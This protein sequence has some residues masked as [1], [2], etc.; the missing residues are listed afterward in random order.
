MT[1]IRRSVIPDRQNIFQILTSPKAQSVFARH[2]LAAV[3]LF[4]SHAEGR[5]TARSDVDLAVLFEDDGSPSARLDTTTTLQ[6]E[7]KRIVPAPMEIVSLNDASPLVEFEATVHG[8]AVYGRDDD[9]A[10]LYELRVRGRYDEFRH[11]QDIFT[12]ALREKLGVSR[13]C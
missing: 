12:D 2:R 9:E 5:A 13:R 10:A 7:L 8:T 11:I 4:G 6:L 1:D 3:Y